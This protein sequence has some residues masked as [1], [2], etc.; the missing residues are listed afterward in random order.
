[1]YLKT[2]SPQ[3]YNFGT[4]SDD[5]SSFPIKKEVIEYKNTNYLRKYDF[6]YSIE[7]IEGLALL[8]LQN[9]DKGF[10]TFVIHRRSIIKPDTPF[11]IVPLTQSAL[12]QESIQ[13]NKPYKENLVPIDTFFQHKPIRPQFYITDI[14]AYYYNVKGQNYNFAGEKHQFWEITYVDTGELHTEIEGEHFTLESQDLVVYLP[15]QF[16]KQ[17]IPKDKSSSY[18]TIMFD[19]RINAKDVERFNKRVFHCTQAMHNLITDFIKQA[20]LMEKYN[21]PYAQDLLVS[22]LQEI[23]IHMIQYDYLESKHTP[24][25]NPIQ[26]KFESEMVNEIV[27]YIN[28]HIYEPITVD[29][30]CDN[31][32]ISRS[33]LQVLF[34]RHI[35]KPP[36]QYINDLKLDLAQKMIRDENLPITDIAIQLGFSSI[37]Y[38]SRKFKK[39]FGLSPS[40]YAQSIFKHTPEN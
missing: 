23:F 16:H 40:E 36:K 25:S 2:T 12:V 10:E 11:T 6:P 20:T 27:N 3:F 26:S 38:F 31:F 13:T 33:T 5:P 34:K 24:P 39:E 37:H 9:E 28:K 17:Y 29:D 21:L 14:F 4:V 15:E 35:N 18:L 7:T 30:I 32:A 19:M 8:V 22:Y 1:M